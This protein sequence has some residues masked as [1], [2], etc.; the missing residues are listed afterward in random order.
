MP[1]SVAR[2]FYFQTKSPNLGKFCSALELKMLEFFM[3][4]MEYFM[5][6]WYNSWPFDIVCGHLVYF[7]DFGKFGPRKI[8]QP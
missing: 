3:T 8:W 1:A 7:S 2:W 6:I 5:A 4:I